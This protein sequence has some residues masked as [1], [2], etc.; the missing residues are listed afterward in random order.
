MFLLNF[1]LDKEIKELMRQGVCFRTIGRVEALP[2]K[3]LERLRE[4]ARLTQNNDRLILN[5]ALNY[6]ART[7]ILDA[8]SKIVSE[9]HGL[10]SN[11]TPFSLSE[12][13]FSRYLY[14]AG[15]PDPDLLIR[16]SGE[17]R[18]SNFLLWQLIL[19]IANGRN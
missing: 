2:P 7:E 13:E 17:M 14:T 15:L 4:A 9:R 18:L 11:G 10:A 19:V 1:F 12:E 8:V 6:G 3:T 5:I 16:T